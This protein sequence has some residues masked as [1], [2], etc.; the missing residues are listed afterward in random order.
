MSCEARRDD[1]VEVG[2]EDDTVLRGEACTEFRPGAILFPTRLVCSCLVDSVKVNGN[3]AG[4]SSF[5]S[6]AVYFLTLW[7]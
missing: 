3:R 2:R 1:D 5:L 7:K 4:R 6:H